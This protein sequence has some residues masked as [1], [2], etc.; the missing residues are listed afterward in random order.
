LLSGER[1]ESKKSLFHLPPL[2]GKWKSY[3]SVLCVS[4]ESRFYPDEWAVK[5]CFNDLTYFM[6]LL[7]NERA[8]FKTKERRNTL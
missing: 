5:K 3:L 8:A 1:T 6:L 7:I 4:N 2:T